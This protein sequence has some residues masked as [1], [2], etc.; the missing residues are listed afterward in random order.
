MS[1]VPSQPSAQNTSAGNPQNFMPPRHHPYP[2]QPSEIHHLPPHAFAHEPSLGGIFPPHT[3]FDSLFHP[4]A[5][6]QQQPQPPRPPSGPTNFH[7]QPVT[8]KPSLLA[9][10]HNPFSSPERNERLISSAINQHQPQG[11]P[12]RFAPPLASP[13]GPSQS[14][15][16]VR[17]ANPAMA[18]AAA[19]A[20]AAALAS[21]GADQLGHGGRG[22]YDSTNAATAAVIAAAN[23]YMN[24][25]GPNRPPV[26]ISPGNTGYA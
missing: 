13:N 21:G 14:M 3:N 9:G 8:R 4:S 5:S 18:E 12:S 7:P 10:Y 24:M 19:A 6:S 15:Q 11:P 23:T 16:S 17:A 22:G 26:N 25:F 1:R 20:L 2:H